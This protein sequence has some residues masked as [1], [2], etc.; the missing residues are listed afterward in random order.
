ML[1]FRK[2]VMNDLALHPVSDDR[3]SFI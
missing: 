2:R 1:L 3:V